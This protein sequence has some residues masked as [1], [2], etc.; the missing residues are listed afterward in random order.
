MY[1]IMI[2]LKQNIIY[3]IFY[4]FEASINEDRKQHTA[5]AGDLVGLELS[6]G[7]TRTRKAWQVTQS[8][9]VSVSAEGYPLPPASCEDLEKV[10]NDHIELYTKDL[11][12]KHI[13]TMVAPFSIS[14]II[15]G[16]QDS[17]SRLLFEEWKV[18]RTVQ[19]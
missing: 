10:I 18:P 17:N 16:R 15:G 9:F 14:N 2:P 13:P 7:N 19:N 3:D 8:W 4:C 5:T 11:P 1:Y 12:P 6:K